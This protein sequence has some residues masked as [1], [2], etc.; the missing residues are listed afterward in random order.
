MNLF[1]LDHNF[2]SCVNWALICLGLSELFLVTTHIPMLFI[3]AHL[4]CA[5]LLPI[6][7][8]LSNS[9]AKGHQLYPRQLLLTTSL[10]LLFKFVF[11]SFALLDF[12]S[13]EL[14]VLQA[15]GVGTF[16]FASLAFAYIYRAF[17]HANRE[18]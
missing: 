13:S 6:H 4:P 16:M 18:A 8:R 7:L 10:L 14:V 17:N 2:F 11:N 3:L 15:I 12:G 5:A 9:Q 1:R